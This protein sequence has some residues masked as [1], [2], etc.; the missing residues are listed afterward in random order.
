M[1]ELTLVAMTPKTPIERRLVL[2]HVVL[3]RQMGYAVEQDEYIE[4]VSGVAVPVVLESGRP[5]A[6]LG[7]VGPTSR[8]AGKIPGIG[9]LLLEHTS[10]LRPN[11]VSPR[12]RHHA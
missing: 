5:L 11:S 3:A 12:L 8:M 1:N 6:A 9:R 7:V 4:G 2:Q 10:A